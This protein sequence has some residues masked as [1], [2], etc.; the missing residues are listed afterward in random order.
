MSVQPRLASS[1]ANAQGSCSGKITATILSAYDLPTSS[2][3]NIQPS[4][5]SMT[6]LGKEVKT[7][8]PSARHRERNSFKFVSSETEGS[9][10]NQLTITAPL[11]VIYPTSITFRVV[12]ENHEA[13][14]A[15]CEPSTVLHVNETQWLILNLKPE[16]SLKD[17]RECKNKSKE[18][19]ETNVSGPTLRLK[20]CLEGPYRSEIAALIS[21]SETWFSIID[22]ITSTSNSSIKSIISVLPHKFPS[23]KIL[24][25]P[26]VPVAAVCVAVLPI[27]LGVLVIGLPFFLPI[28]VILLA[29]LIT[30]LTLGTGVYLSSSSGRKS[31]AALL[32]PIYSTFNATIAG[33]KMLFQTGPRPSPVAL[34]ETIMPDDMAGKLIVSLVIDFI[35]SSSYLLPGVGEGFDVAWAPIQTILLMAMYDST[36]P[37]LKYISFMEEI[38]PFTDLLPSG[39]LGWVREYS[40][41]IMEEGMKKVDDL[42]VVMRGEGEALR[43]GVRQM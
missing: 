25:V 4:Y 36:M 9:S 8:P 35:G 27:V 17:D 31:A 26:T 7:G 38:I 18:A 34:A 2:T 30:A 13:L 24:L 28:L 32:G 11:S 42:R 20:L 6:M 10:G 39:T 3:G 40:P 5:V 21:L 33:Q 15:E 29:V 16:S 43:E 12:L 41:L 1:P 22:G 23:A 19:E 14:V 37:S